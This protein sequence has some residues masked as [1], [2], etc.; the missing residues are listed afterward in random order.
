MSQ[1]D[2]KTTISEVIDRKWLGISSKSGNVCSCT[3]KRACSLRLCG[4][5]IGGKKDNLKPMWVKL[6]KQVDVSLL[7]QE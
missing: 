4:R 2:V 7:D 5:H 3:S 6:K 1:I